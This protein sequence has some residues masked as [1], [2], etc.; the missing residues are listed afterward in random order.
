MKSILL[1]LMVAA[2][3]SLIAER[4]EAM[5]PEEMLKKIHWL[6]QATVK[7]EAG[8]QIIYIDPVYNLEETHDADLILITHS[9]QD[10]YDIGKLKLL[11]QEGTVVIAPGDITAKI[12]DALG[13][14]SV[15]AEPGF[16]TT[17][18]AV[19]IEAV[20]AYNIV[21]TKFHPK[22]N[23]WVG[24]VLTIDGVRVY[25]AGDTER[26][27]EMQEFTADIAM[28]PLGQTYT[29]H[30]VEEAADAVRDVQAKIAIPIHYGMYE[31]TAADAQKFAELLQG[32]MS[33]VLMDAPR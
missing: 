3:T 25:H 8:E 10:H 16:S 17:V 4:A 31:G 21:K 24:Y 28:L 18:G 30:S 2:L 1:I 22:A 29:M 13:T 27:P 14:T 6:G 20:P 15:A 9:H 23:N 32:E 5:T 11:V 26:V 12:D 33:V 19:A 7:I